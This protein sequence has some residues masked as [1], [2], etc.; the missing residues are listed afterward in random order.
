MLYAL[1]CTDKP[2]SVDLRAKVRPDHVAYLG[3]LGDKMKAAGPF[4]DDLGSPIG[5]LVII[6]A[7]NREAA[8][9][10]A[11]ADPYALAGLFAA[12]EIKAWRWALKNPDAA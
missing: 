7:E 4:L 3:S 9:A 2:A 1:L 10:M 5:S 8:Q 11:A 12:V 6:E